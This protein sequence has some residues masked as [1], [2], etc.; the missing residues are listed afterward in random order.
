[1]G[2]E[3]TAMN[4]SVSICI[5]ALLSLFPLNSRARAQD[6]EVL[7]LVQ[8]IAMPNVKGRIDHMDVDVDGKRLFVAAVE[9]G[10]IEVVDLATGKWIRSIPGFKTPTE[11]VYVRELNKLFVAS[12]DDGMVRVFRGD[13]LD[14]VDSIKLELGVNRI[15][16]DPGSKYL[17]VGYGA[18]LAGFDYGRVGIIDARSDKLLRDIVVDS[19]PSQILLDRAANHILVAVWELGQINMFDAK[20]HQLLLSWTTGGQSG[21]MAL[22]QTHHRLFVATRTPPQMMIVF[23]SDSGQEV[24]RLPAEG[25]MNG[26]YYD[27]WHK[28]IYVTC[29]RDLPAGFVFVY[30]QKDADHYESIGKLSTGPGAGTSF[31]VPQLNRFYVAVPA[32]E[33]Q[34]AAVLIFEPQP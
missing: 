10:S 25:R 26:V 32:A 23:D 13:S 19:H 30:Q 9:N 21:D 6:K 12:R 16:Y 28:R 3:V 11:M 17:Y 22:D 31:W 29:G 20:D 14:L 34:D 1:L 33:K 15:I 7:H 8:T 27:G 4:K 18:K 5:T 24:A 2:G